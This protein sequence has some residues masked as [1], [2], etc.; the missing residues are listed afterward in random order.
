MLYLYLIVF[1][2]HTLLYYIIIF[3]FAG[4]TRVVDP[5]RDDRDTESNATSDEDQLWKGSTLY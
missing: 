5:V 3:I 2:Y 1:N 4:G